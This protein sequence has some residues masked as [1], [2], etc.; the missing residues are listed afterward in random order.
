[1]YDEIDSYQYESHFRPNLENAFDY[2]FQFPMTQ[3]CL[4]SATVGSFS[5]P[6]IK[7]EPV[8]EVS[9]TDD[10]HRLL[11]IQPTNDPKV[12]TVDIIKELTDKY[13]N[14]KILIAYNLVTRGILPIIKSL[15]EELQK[16]CSV[17]CGTKS[18][19]HVQE[20]L[21]EVWDNKLPSR[22]TFITSTYFV[23]VDFSERFHLVSVCDCSHP[24][25]L[26]SSAK[27]QQIAGRCRHNEG[28]LSETIVS[29]FYNDNSEPIDYISLEQKILS[30]ADSLVSL[31]KSFEK[32][33]DS[34]PK[35]IKS[36]NEIYFADFVE[37]SF[38][39]YMGSSLTRL[40]REKDNTLAI[41]YFN[42]DSIMIQVRLLHTTY[43]NPQCLKS[44]LEEEGCL[45]TLLP[46]KF[47]TDG[48]SD[49]V[50][51][52]IAKIKSEN[53]S[54]IRENIINEL[55][56]KNTYFERIAL[57][58][59]RRNDATNAV[60]V[61]L[62]HFIELHKFIPFEPLINLLN[63][64]DTPRSFNHLR[65]ATYFWALHPDHPIKLALSSTFIIE[66]QYTGKELV[67]KI[68][69][70]WSGALGNAPLNHNS[71]I[72]LAKEYFVELST[73]TKRLSKNKMPER[74]YKV[75]SFNPKGLPSEHIEMI[76]PTV[77]IQRMIKM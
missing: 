10:Q 39:R 37:S 2:Y 64:N 68:N 49:E 66:K 4:I 42:I 33:K 75:I 1:M 25:T 54:N 26:L 45:V 34:F 73:T 22:I 63:D 3:R 48:V 52:E 32:I 24:F 55:R 35:L 12:C 41:S 53:D 31:S 69:S 19:A 20:Y 60:G 23:G 51:K 16:E 72:R 76:D 27:L 71:A 30:D 29:S 50:L 43:T 47:T 8:I 44:N 36:Y 38:K 13:P 28:L 58:R 57:A 62:E 14:D 40:V 5:N 70:I 46:F 15:P 17:L 7:E 59:A 61:F 6:L 9:F 67:E 11:S 74:V 21:K 56:D 18:Q 65:N 77:N